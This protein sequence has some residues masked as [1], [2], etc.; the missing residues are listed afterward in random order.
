MTK[1][2]YLDV[3]LLGNLVMNLL[4]LWSTAKFAKINPGRW[5]LLSG[6]AVGSIYALTVFIPELYVFLPWICK[7][8]ISILM[9]LM[10]FGVLQWRQF[11]LTLLYFYLS[12]FAIGGL[13]FGSMYFMQSAS[14]NDQAF[15]LSHLISNFFW[16]AIVLAITITLV[17][18]KWG[19]LIHRK[20]LLQHQFKRDVVIKIS[21]QQ[22]ELEGLLDTGNSLTDP[23]TGLPVMVVEY[24]AVKSIL[25]E[26]IAQLY[27]SGKVIDFDQVQQA[28]SNKTLAAQISMIPYKSLGKT[29]GLL[30]GLRPDAVEIKTNN[31]VISTT[32]VIVAVHQGELT[33]GNNYQVLLH[34]ELIS[35]A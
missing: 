11:L 1:V 22:V 33:S 19:S 4:I 20:R 13:V 34:P 32:K 31:Q 25:P 9:V 35:V 10:T 3:V 30:L 6:A 26:G 18:G 16:P 27:Q 12:S 14:Y 7:L 29:N 17:V 15:S 28:V 23:L 24:K 5:R 21:N 8:A 2:I